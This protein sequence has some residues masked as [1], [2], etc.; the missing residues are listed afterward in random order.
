METEPL[1]SADTANGEV[2]SK[3]VNTASLTGKRDINGLLRMRSVDR[4]TDGEQFLVYQGVE[5]NS[6]LRLS[7]SGSR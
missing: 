5:I 6:A 1:T 2:A 4:Q 3:A 7:Y